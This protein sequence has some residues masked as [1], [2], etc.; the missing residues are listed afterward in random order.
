M[1]SHYSS[2]SQPRLHLAARA[3]ARSINMA[4]MQPCSRDAATVG[5]TPNNIGHEQ[6]TPI[7]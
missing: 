7:Y 2:C 5:C 3:A 6:E 4:L 1:A